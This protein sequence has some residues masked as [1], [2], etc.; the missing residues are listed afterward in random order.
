[1]AALKTTTFVAQ[2]TPNRTYWGFFIGLGVFCTI[3]MLFA[4]AVAW[5]LGS[6]PAETLRSLR[7][8]SWAVAAAFAAASCASASD[9][10]LRSGVT[11][12][13]EAPDR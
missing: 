13:R 5:Q 11:D 9:G 1:M 2:G 12:G 4:A 8:V 10:A 7:F 6:V 3:L